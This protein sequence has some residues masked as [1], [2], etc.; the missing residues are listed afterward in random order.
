MKIYITASFV[1]S[2]CIA[3]FALYAGI[4]HNAMGEFCKDLDLDECKLD[5]GYAAFI[6]FS[7][8]IPAF[9][10]QSLLVVAVR[11]INSFPTKR[12]SGH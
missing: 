3:S 11:Y 6:W 1:I 4:S 12:S 5:L 10:A 9:L 7:R 2:I 8:F